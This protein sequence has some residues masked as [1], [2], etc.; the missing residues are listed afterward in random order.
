MK[1]N[2]KIYYD[3]KG[4]FLEIH[5]GKY[6]EGYFRNLGR[7][8][9]ERIDKKTGNVTGVAISSFK[10]RTQGLKQLDVTLPMK[11]ELSS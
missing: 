7:G 2:L 8:V 3:E 1:G 9:F 11:I 10:K 4:D 6:K 5:I